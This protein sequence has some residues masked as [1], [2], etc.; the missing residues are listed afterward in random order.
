[1]TA[2]PEVL[3][4]KLA[5]LQRFLEDLAAFGPLPHEERV[6]QHYAIERLL[7]LL[8][9]AAADIGLQIL[10]HETG[11]GAGSYREIF[12]RLRERA[13]LPVQLAEGLMEA[14]A[15]RNVLTHLYDTIDTD[16]VAAAVDPALDLYRRYL[17][18]VVARMRLS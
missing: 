16:R 9:E 2:R 4:R 8:C 1:M 17:A 12:Q 11:E 6:R 15:M 18:W 10:R 5:A 13:E 7:Q 3:E 14:C